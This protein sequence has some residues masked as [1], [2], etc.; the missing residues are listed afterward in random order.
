MHRAREQLAAAGEF[1]AEQGE[2]FKKYLKRDLE[3]TAD[4]MRARSLWAI[5]K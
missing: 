3:Q 4:D 2:V 1:T 5:R